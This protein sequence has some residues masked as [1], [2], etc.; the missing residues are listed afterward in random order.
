M[1]FRTTC[2]NAVRF[3]TDFESDVQK[4]RNAARCLSCQIPS[5]NRYPMWPFRLVLWPGAC[6]TRVLTLGEGRGYWTSVFTANRYLIDTLATKSALTFNSTP[7]PGSLPSIV[8]TRID[9]RLTSLLKTPFD[10]LHTVIR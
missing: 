8:C 7:S 3:L 6:F 5:V 1:F 9:T 10:S 4:Y 2:G